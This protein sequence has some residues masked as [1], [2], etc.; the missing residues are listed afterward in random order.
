MVT[1]TEQLQAAYE[2][3]GSTALL[4]EMIQGHKI[5]SEVL[6]GFVDNLENAQKELKK[7][8]TDAAVEQIK[9]LIAAHN[10]DSALLKGVL[11]AESKASKTVKA[12][13]GS[14]KAPQHKHFFANEKGEVVQGEFAAIGKLPSKKESGNPAGFFAWATE[15]VK[16]G[17]KMTREDFRVGTM[18][19]GEM[20]DIAIEYYNH[21]TTSSAA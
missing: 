21:I 1:K 3:L 8:E 19:E 11:P 10:L 18:T 15:R 14:N 2:V 6:G 17:K 20:E 12:S 9:E 4:K 5:G 13:T 16:D 7:I